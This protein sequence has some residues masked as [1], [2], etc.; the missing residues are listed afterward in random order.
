MGTTSIC[1]VKP[2]FFESTF[3][4]LMLFEIK[5][6]LFLG[7]LSIFVVSPQK[8]VD[9]LGLGIRTIIRIHIPTLVFMRILILV[10]FH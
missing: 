2:L 9:L 4:F 5:P 6:P 1:E 3:Q 8:I 10:R 7:V